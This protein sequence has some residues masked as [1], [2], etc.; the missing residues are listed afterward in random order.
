[1]TIES[2]GMMYTHKHTQ[3]HT[4]THKHT[5]LSGENEFKTQRNFQGHE[6]EGDLQQI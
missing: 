1:M 5:H 2:S 4:N 3:T 6:K